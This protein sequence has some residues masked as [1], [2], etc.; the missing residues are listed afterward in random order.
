MPLMITLRPATLDD[1]P[2]VGALFT[3]TRRTCMPYL[4]A[5]HTADEDHAWMRDVVFKN[6]DVWIAEVDGS[7]AGFLAVEGDTLAHLYVHPEHHS[8]G[9]GTALLAKARELRPNGFR[10]WVFQRN[11]QARHFYERNG[12]RLAQLTDGAT[13]EER[14]PDAQYVW[15]LEPQAANS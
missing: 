15:C 5:L 8:R 14:T 12:L 11:A 9:V 4:P 1:V 3:H 13:N 2:P 10:L 6:C 7:L